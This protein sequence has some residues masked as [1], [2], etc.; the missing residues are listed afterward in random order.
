ME[1]GDSSREKKS[2]TGF[3]LRKKKQRQP[4]DEHES[5]QVVELFNIFSE[6][7]GKEK[8][9][10]AIKDIEEIIDSRKQDLATKADILGVKAD[11]LEVK[12]DILEVKKEIKEVEL[13]IEQVRSNLIKWVVG[14]VIAQTSITVTLIVALLK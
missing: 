11:I 4:Q 7:F 9:Q 1:E 2:T 14:L 13:K 12:A 10:V 8:A 3:L 6:T 5:T